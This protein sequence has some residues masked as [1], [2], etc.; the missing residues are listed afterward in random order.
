MLS[1]EWRYGYFGLF[2]DLPGALDW[3]GRM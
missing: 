3:L 2:D 1:D